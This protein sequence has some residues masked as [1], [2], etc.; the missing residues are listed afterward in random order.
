[1][2]EK[3]VDVAAISAAYC[4]QTDSARK[5]PEHETLGNGF[6]SAKVDNV[7]L[8]LAS[9]SMKEGRLTQIRSIES[10]VRSAR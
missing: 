1:M 2:C 5:M 6:V 7:E 3:L 9:S 10:Q 8:S 4:T